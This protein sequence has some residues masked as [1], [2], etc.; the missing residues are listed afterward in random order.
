MREFFGC[1]ETFVECISKFETTTETTKITDSTTTISHKSKTTQESAKSFPL[2][3]F[4]VSIAIGLIIVA[5]IALIL[6][7]FVYSMSSF[8]LNISLK[9]VFKKFLEP[10]NDSS[11]KNK[12]SKIKETDGKKNIEKE[13]SLR[14]VQHDTKDLKT[15]SEKSQKQ[16]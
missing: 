10:A 9:S 11:Q 1:N 7:F 6:F 12:S 16:S 14:S 15:G 5:A 3:Y 4:I 8:F 2:V 13:R